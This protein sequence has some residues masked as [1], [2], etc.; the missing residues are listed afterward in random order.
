MEAAYHRKIELQSTEDFAYLAN[1]VRRATAESLAAAFPPVE[2]A[3]DKT[4]SSKARA[5]GR[6]KASANEADDL[7][8]R[9]EALVN[10]VR[11]GGRRGGGKEGV[12][13]K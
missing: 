7:H 13:E 1:N 2:D 10:E 12:D 3:E 9:V 5:K 6:K 11:E 8:T 4:G